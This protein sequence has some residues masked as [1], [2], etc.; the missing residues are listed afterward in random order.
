MGNL[1][2]ILLVFHDESNGQSVTE[3]SSGTMHQ[4]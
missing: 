3:R 1:N 4:E 2:K